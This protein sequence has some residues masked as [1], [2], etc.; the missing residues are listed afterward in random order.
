MSGLDLPEIVNASDVA[1]Y[2]DTV[3]VLV[4]GAGI[5]GCC[6]AA[7]AAST[8]A[9]VLV[10]ERSAAA[11]ATTCMAGGHF[12]L[13]GGTAVQQATGHDDS[14][15]EMAK[16]LTAVSLDPEPDKIKAYCDD[17]VEHF[18]WLGLWAFSSSGPIT[19]RRPS[20]SRRPRG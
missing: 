4:I 13:G 3:D 6:A 20:S 19:R 1:H 16:Y 9:S 11:G 10:L 12:Y 14:P 17:S 18:N 15:E 5:G 7:E 8:G 2:T